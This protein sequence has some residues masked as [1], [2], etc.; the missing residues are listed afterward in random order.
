M[1]VRIDPPRQPDVH[2]ALAQSAHAIAPVD[3][4]LTLTP[5][6]GQ[7]NE[8]PPVRMFV[9]L[10]VLT[11]FVAIAISGGVELFLMR[12]AQTRDAST[13][14]AVFE[15]H[16]KLVRF[17]PITFMVGLAFGVA[18]IFVNGFNPFAPWLL[19][20]YP[21]FVA[22]IL[23]G[24]FGVGP[25]AEGVIAA[26]ALSGE[27]SAAA[28]AAAV[29]SPRGRNAMLLFWAITAAIIFVMVMKPLS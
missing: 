1:S 2:Q 16:Q 24:A 19:L 14:R 20:A 18:A 28:L 6:V 23:T 9:F 26:S 13:I 22:G 21:L 8:D 29:T 7:L 10:H 27:G 17:I 4:R 5:P 25:W 3:T 12:V 11:M 15:L